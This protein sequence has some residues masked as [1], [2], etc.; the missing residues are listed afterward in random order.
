M[1][2]KVYATLCLASQII[3][4]LNLFFVPE[5]RNFSLPLPLISENYDYLSS[6]AYLNIV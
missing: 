6:H 4:Y 1:H 5:R 2:N 3:F